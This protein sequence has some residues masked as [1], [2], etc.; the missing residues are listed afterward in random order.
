MHTTSQTGGFGLRGAEN[1]PEGFRRLNHEAMSIDVPAELELRPAKSPLA[2]MA[3]APRG[4]LMGSSVTLVVL[5]ELGDTASLAEGFMRGAEASGAKRAGQR[6]LSV[7][8]K[9][10]VA[11][12]FTR[13]SKPVALHGMVRA[14]AT[15]GR[16][17][18]ATC[19]AKTARFEDV[20]ARCGEHLGRIDA[21]PKT[22]GDARATLPFLKED[23]WRESSDQASGD[24]K[25]FSLVLE[26]DFHL[27]VR[28][29]DVAI[30][31]GAAPT[32]VLARYKAAL[33][34]DTTGN[35]TFAGFRSEK[36]AKD[37]T[38][39][40]EF[41]EQADGPPIFGTTLHVPTDDG[42]YAVTCAGPSREPVHEACRAVL[43]SVKVR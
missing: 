21:A 39:T 7:G 6:P 23:A 5:H 11:M 37:A 14:I 32:A 24:G 28:L 26:D 10:A 13:P 25:V 3:A 12:D 19:H 42:H 20:R 1:P 2:L 38:M 4:P 43:A 27:A 31:D 33:S 17:V 30:T 36:R 8:G 40:A 9:Q 29:V 34:K 22:R 16:L 35:T 15:S 18:V 41:D